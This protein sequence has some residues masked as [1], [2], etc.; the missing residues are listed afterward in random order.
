V[1]TIHTDEARREFLLATPRQSGRAPLV[2]SFHG[3]DQTARWI[4]RYTGLSRAGT[5]LGFVVATPQGLLDRWNFP[6]RSSIGPDDVR[7]VAAMVR[8]LTVHAC[9]DRRAV[10]LTGFSDGADMANTVACARPSL[11]RAV[12]AVAASMPP[13]RCR[14]PVDTLQIHGNRDPIVPFA[15][16]GGDR[17]WPFESTE[18][19]PALAQLH[20]WQ[21]LDGC[22]A[23]TR[24]TTIRPGIEVIAAPGCRS[25]RSAEL[26]V[27]DGGGHTWPGAAVQLPYGATTRALSA[28]Y[29]ILYFFRHL[30]RG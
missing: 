12:A 17:G 4:D 6:R 3:F 2:V 7:F 9:V 27:V 15:G 25:G 10:F 30:I 14:G 16:G 5:R 19:M 24:A 20:A 1:V 13:L 21:R 8:W 23:P 18:A 22:S 28:T 29:R 26:I 11:V